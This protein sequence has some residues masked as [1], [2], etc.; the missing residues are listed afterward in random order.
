M[1]HFRL[2]TYVEYCLEELLPSRR[3][4]KS[5]MFVAS[6]HGSML[7]RHLIDCYYCREVRSSFLHTPISYGL[8]KLLECWRCRFTFHLYDELVTRPFI[9]YPCGWWDVR[10]H[11]CECIYLDRLGNELKNGIS[12]CFAARQ[13]PSEDDMH[14]MQTISNLEIYDIEAPERVE[15]RGVLHEHGYVMVIF[16]FL[17]YGI[18][19]VVSSRPFS[20]IYRFAKYFARYTVQKLALLRDKHLIIKYLH[21]L[22]VH[23]LMHLSWSIRQVLLAEAVDTISLPGQLFSQISPA[24]RE[25]SFLY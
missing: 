8:S 14:F 4:K 18:E 16:D 7:N 19:D 11:I 9:C 21:W 12:F 17:D 15:Y 20:K 22:D 2:L 24:R 13:C 1:Y 10:D 5:M 6:R 25:V 23:A 3:L